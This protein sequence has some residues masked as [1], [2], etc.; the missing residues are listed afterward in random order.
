MRMTD[1]SWIAAELDAIGRRSEYA[2]TREPADARRLLAAARE[3]LRLADRWQKR[4][5]TGYSALA[6]CSSELRR[7]IAQEL[8][9][10]PS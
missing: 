10:G 9:G 4:S 2:D 8:S 5:T 6:D 7:V 1:T 3:A